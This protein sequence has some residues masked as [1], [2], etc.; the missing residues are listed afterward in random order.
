MRLALVVMGMLIGMSSAFAQDEPQPA[1]SEPT[2]TAA[3]RSPG[4]M[5]GCCRCRSARP[6]SASRTTRMQLVRY[7]P[8]IA[9]Y[10]H[11]AAWGAHDI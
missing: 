4:A 10:D 2:S 3:P 5:R 6:G 1:P 7:D 8:P 11:T 9:D